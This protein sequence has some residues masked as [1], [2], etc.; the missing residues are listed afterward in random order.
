[1]KLILGSAQ[2]GMKY[3]ISNKK[4]KTSSRE[5]KK[6]LKYAHKKNISFIDTA[7]AYKVSEKEIGNYH[8]KS[9]N[10]FK[11]ITKFSIKNGDVRKQFEKSKK[12]LRV[13]PH[14]ILAHSAKDYTSIK[15]QEK[16][17]DIKSEFKSVKF[18]VSLYDPEEF[19]KIIKVKVPDIIQV[20]INLF[21]KRFLDPK[22]IKLAERNRIKIHARS[23]FLQGLFFLKKHKI[24]KTFKNVEYIF[25][26]FDQVCRYEKINLG[27]LS[28]LWLYK[29][30]EVDKIILGVNSLKQLRVNLKT[31]KKKINRRSQK[32]IEELNLNQ[33]IIIKPKLW[34]IKQA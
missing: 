6:I 11:I 20:P 31:I 19:Y 13:L 15:F 30:K 7:Y 3:G 28:L 9:R 27:Q 29:K 33:N 5:V 16:I 21:D 34:K 24:F 8:L 1:M 14:I 12:N 10:K 23:V 17:K 25:N 22:I 32:I 2:F 4:G 26:R 18:G